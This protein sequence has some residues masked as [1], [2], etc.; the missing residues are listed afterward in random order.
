[1]LKGALPVTSIN[2]TTCLL[3]I[4]HG[5]DTKLLPMLLHFFDI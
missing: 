5:K 4:A 3:R 1:M 2:Y